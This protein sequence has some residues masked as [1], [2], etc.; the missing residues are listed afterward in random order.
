MAAAARKVGVYGSVCARVA[1]TLVADPDD[2]HVTATSSAMEFQKGAFIA[3]DDDV[4]AVEKIYA[5]N[6]A[7]KKS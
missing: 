7:T 2:A 4:G 1:E 6:A 3:G 5:F